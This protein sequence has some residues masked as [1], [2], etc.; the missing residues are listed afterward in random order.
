MSWHCD[1]NY[2][3]GYNTDVICI[4]KRRERMCMELKK[5]K[6]RT[7]DLTCS[8]GLCCSN[9]WSLTGLLSIFLIVLLSPV[10]L[11]TVYLKQAVQQL[12]IHLGIP[13][14]QYPV[15]VSGD[16]NLGGGPVW[17]GVTQWA[18]CMCGYKRRCSAS[19]VNI[20]CMRVVVD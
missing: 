6:K 13:L 12:S 15:C 19:V 11:L 4:T 17:R 2:G 3:N 7:A 20:F 18:W 14:S 5:K 9:G 16:W 8:M 1:Q 10:L